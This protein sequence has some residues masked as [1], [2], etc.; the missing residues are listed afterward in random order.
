VAVYVPAVSAIDEL[1]VEKTKLK[2]RLA[3]QSWN[4]AMPGRDATVSAQVLKGSV[5]YHA[6]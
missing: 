4:F 2:A 1:S 5:P 3:G 6:N